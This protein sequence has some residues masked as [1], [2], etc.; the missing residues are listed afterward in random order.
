MEIWTWLEKHYNQLY[1]QQVADNN[2]NNSAKAIV[3][4]LLKHKHNHVLIDL[5]HT[6]GHDFLSQE[7]Y[8]ATLKQLIFSLYEEDKLTCLIMSQDYLKEFPECIS[9]LQV[10]GFC[11]LMQDKFALAYEVFDTLVTLAPDYD[12][13]HLLL[14]VS[15]RASEQMS[16]VMD[17]VKKINQSDT[18]NLITQKVILNFSEEAYDSYKALVT[19][20]GIAT[21]TEIKPQPQLQKYRQALVYCPVDLVL[22]PSDPS[23]SFTVVDSTSSGVKALKVLNEEPYVFFTLQGVNPDSLAPLSVFCD[24]FDLG[25]TMINPELAITPSKRH[26]PE[27]LAGFV[28]GFAGRKTTKLTD[29]HDWLQRFSDSQEHPLVWLDLLKQ[30]DSSNPNI[31]K[32][33][34]KQEIVVSTYCLEDY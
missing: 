11:A 28:M 17:S 23:T 1:T 25:S 14:I 29:L 27:F 4:W 31:A 7:E 18:C 15:A 10:Q 32:Q 5:I 34:E 16:N 19:H 24:I 6:C 26:L 30:L 3:Q 20:H 33:I 9:I 21:V 12:V 8:K 2:K 22:N 13:Y